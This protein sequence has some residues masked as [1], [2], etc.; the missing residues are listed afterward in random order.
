[1]RRLKSYS[2]RDIE[3]GARQEVLSEIE[4]ELKSGNAGVLFDLG[5]SCSTLRRYGSARAARRNAASARV[6][7]PAAAAKAE[8]FGITAEHVVDDVIALLVGSC[9]HHLL[10]NHT[11]L[12]KGSDPKACTR[13]ASPCAGC[14]RSVRCSG[15]I[16]R[17]FHSRRSTAKRGG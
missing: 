1:M 2:T 15:A 4:L 7:R 14:G 11:V 12:E 5:T 8:L 17:R 3:A 16:F 13:C 10:K 9:W 6:R